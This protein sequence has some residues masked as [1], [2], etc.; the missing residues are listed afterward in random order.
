MFGNTSMRFLTICNSCSFL[1]YIIAP[2]VVK[3]FMVTF[4][5]CGFW[6]GDLSVES[7]ALREWIPDQVRND[8]MKSLILYYE[9]HCRGV[10]FCCWA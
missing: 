7:P 5:G 2:V 6:V 1:G 3:I 8:T 9:V 10:A 4:F